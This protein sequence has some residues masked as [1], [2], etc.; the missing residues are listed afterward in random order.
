MAELS[1]VCEIAENLTGRFYIRR[2]DN[3]RLAWS[4]ARWV[5]HFQGVGYL[6]QVSNYSTHA[7]AEQAVTTLGMPLKSPLEPR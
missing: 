1:P 6:W 2:H 5:E 4:G 3:P 7:E